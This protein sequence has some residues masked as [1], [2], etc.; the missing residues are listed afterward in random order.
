MELCELER[1]A[2]SAE[3]VLGW[4]GCQRNPFLGEKYTGRSG[5]GQNR[6]DVGREGGMVRTERGRAV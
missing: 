1:P 5:G 6:A 4:Q 3:L 2:C